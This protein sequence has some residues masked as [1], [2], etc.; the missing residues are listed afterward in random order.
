MKFTI[1]C[2]KEYNVIKN[3]LLSSLT[4]CKNIISAIVN[5]IKTTIPAIIF[6]AIFLS[7]GKP[8]NNNVFFLNAVVLG[9]HYKFLML[10]YLI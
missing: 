6:T 2:K 9:F 8:K 5:N 4:D 7:F 1:I 10:V 3:G